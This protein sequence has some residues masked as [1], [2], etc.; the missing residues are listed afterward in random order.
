MVLQF[1]GE[2]VVGLDCYAPFRAEQ[3]E[4]PGPSHY[5]GFPRVFGAMPVKFRDKFLFD[6]A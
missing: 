2:V 1:I 6:E 3:V 4:E 5:P